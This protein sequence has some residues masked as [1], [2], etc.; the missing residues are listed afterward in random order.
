MKKITTAPKL[1]N[2]SL[3]NCFAGL[4][5]ALMADTLA[6]KA[7][8]EDIKTLNIMLKKLSFEMSGITYL[9]MP[10]GEYKLGFDFE[11]KSIVCLQSGK[12]APINLTAA[13]IAARKNAHAQLDELLVHLRRKFENKAKASIESTIKVNPGHAQSQSKTGIFGGTRQA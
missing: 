4:E 1:S 5:E 2:E 11:K 3:A 13:P 10:H 6:L 8:D 12:P 7:M 9:D